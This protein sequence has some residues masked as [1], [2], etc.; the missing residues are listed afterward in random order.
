MN[1][2]PEEAAWNEETRRIMALSDS[3]S[4]VNHAIREIAKDMAR[5][6]KADNMPVDQIIKYTGL[7]EKQ[8]KGL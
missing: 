2:T 4:G 6:M 5:K 8:I 7:T 1:V 3:T